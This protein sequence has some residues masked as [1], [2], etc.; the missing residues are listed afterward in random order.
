MQTLTEYPVL[1][2]LTLGC[3]ASY[4]ARRQP[5]T[6]RLTVFAPGAQGEPDIAAL[7][8][9]IESAW[10]PQAGPLLLNLANEA[11]LDALLRAGPPAFLH[12]EVP[13]FMAAD[14]TRL[15]TLQTLAHAGHTLVLTSR[16]A[17]P[18]PTAVVACFR[19][20]I[21]DLRDAPAGTP[22]AVGK[23]PAGLPFLQA[24]CES[25]RQVAASFQAGASG[26]LGWPLGEPPE[27]TARPRPV[28]P[29]VQVV[30]DLMQRVDREEP[31]ARLEAV[32]RNDPTLAFRLMRYINSPAFG[33]SVEISSFQHAVMI[34][35][36][37][38]LKRW[39]ALLLAGAIDDPDQKPL[40]ALAVRR[41][42]L[43]EALAPADGD[44][45]VGQ[46]M[47]IC[48]VFSLL[49]RMLGQSFGK[50]LTELPVADAVRQA[51]VDGDG[52]HR[53]FLDLACAVE[54]ESLFDIREATEALMITPGEANR[55]V[56]K[57]LSSARQSGLD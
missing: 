22:A 14:P 37:R 29:G 21:V 42:L 45:S 40:M 49:D 46:E 43:M 6:A 55:A 25:A 36:Y 51:L 38:R 13:A 52:P 3:T 34:L 56:L 48:G 54:T 50:L 8:A 15:D 9:A 19:Q 30:M 57:A 44:P 24:G 53:P 47:F 39:L 17:V 7:L 23:A 10:P 18:P 20:A 41:A 31:A 1:D 2:A 16:P 35:G 5:H 26:V 32:L 33:L 28:P 27:D 12:I 11:W 4:D